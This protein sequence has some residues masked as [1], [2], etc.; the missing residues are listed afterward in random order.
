MVEGISKRYEIGNDSPFAPASS[1]YSSLRDKR[2]SGST[3][4]GHALDY[5]ELDDG[6]D[7]FD[8]EEIVAEPSAD[9][10]TPPR[11]DDW[12]LMDV[13]FTVPTGG[14]LGVL[15]HAGAGKSTLLRILAGVSLPTSGRAVL[16]GTVAPI[17]SV[18]AS[19]MRLELSARQNVLATARL[20]GVPRATVRRRVDDVLAF[21]GVT[22]HHRPPLR[23]AG[24]LFRRLAL[25]A[26][27][28]L[29]PD[30]LLLDELPRVVDHDFQE[31]WFERLRERMDGGLAVVVAGRSAEPMHPI[32]SELLWLDGGRTV[33]RGDA[34]RVASA[35][36]LS[37]AV[38][39]Q[40][41]DP[42]RIEHREA[43]FHRWAAL[44]GAEACRADGQ[45]VDRISAN[46]EIVV[47][48]RAELA[49]RR[50]EIRWAITFARADG[51][52]VR[53]EQPDRATYPSD[54]T[55]VVTARI[56]AGTLE[57]G[58]YVAR[59]DGAVAAKGQE[60]VIGRTS[61][62]LDVWSPHD[63]AEMPPV[64]PDTPL[65]GPVAGF[66]VLADAGWHIESEPEPRLTS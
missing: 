14:A 54:G 7:E 26:A 66:T 15:G 41:A 35:Y 29:D 11:A 43:G 1:I 22:A 16:S 42:V 44:L 45:P 59:V 10:M 61:F 46:R 18:T 32:C 64:T 37:T 2:T 57:P 53:V 8:D 48:L 50:M 27:I 62:T 33:D 12:A 13:S 58:E 65:D 5:G 40:R 28:N 25:S 49:A 30:V 4:P 63:L 34:G 21:A 31:R 47:R 3:R 20:F 51:S 24:E 56:P 38:S 23:E 19:F 6:D 55:Y 39:R 9:W 17:P 60:I 52:S 36:E